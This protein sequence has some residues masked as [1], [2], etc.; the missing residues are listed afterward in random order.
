MFE[1]II[2]LIKNSLDDENIVVVKQSTYIL[3]NFLLITN[4]LAL[5]VYF[6]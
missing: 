3:Y 1:I 4:I 2:N 5:I 6:N